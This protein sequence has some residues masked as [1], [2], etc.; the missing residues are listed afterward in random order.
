MLIHSLYFMLH[1]FWGTVSSILPTSQLSGQLL[2]IYLRIHDTLVS[3]TTANLTFVPFL[4]CHLINTQDRP[5]KVYIF[6]K[7]RAFYTYFKKEKHRNKTYKNVMVYPWFTVV[8]QLQM[9]LY[10]SLLLGK[11]AEFSKL[12][13]NVYFMGSILSR[14][15]SRVP[16]VT[17]CLVSCYFWR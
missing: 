1:V 12:W 17:E 4:C 15:Q 9:W 6:L 8:W 13:E 16:K 5:H 7:L 10:F 11:H 3:K 2:C 14:Y